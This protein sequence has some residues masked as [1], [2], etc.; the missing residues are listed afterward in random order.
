MYDQIT[1]DRALA[2][3]D[4]GISL[5]VTSQITGVSRATLKDWR[6]HPNRSRRPADCVRCAPVPSLPEPQWEYAYLLGLYLGDGCI[7]AS[8]NP[9]KGVWLLRIACAD[10][11]P[12][13]QAECRAAISAIRPSNKVGTAQQVGCIQVVCSWRHW[14]CLFPQH[15][16]GKKHLRK[17][18]LAAWQ[19]DIVDRVPGAFV[20]GLFHSDGCRVVNRVRQPLASG[21]RSYEYPRYFFSNESTD[22]MGLCAQTLD[23]LGVNWR[24]ARPNL[25]SVARRESVARMDE[26]VGPKY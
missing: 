1:R 7:S 9:A 26:L 15:G 5:R 22:I 21:N 14:P 2:L 6:E 4:N 23:Q 11:W 16:P 17:I 8:G 24:M 10:A 12:G 3:I 25:L 18:E 13:L 19:Q 20:R